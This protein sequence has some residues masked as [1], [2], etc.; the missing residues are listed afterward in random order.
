MFG[1]KQVDYLVPDR[2]NLGYG[3]SPQLA[4]QVVALKPDV[5]ITVDNGISCLQG[6][7][8]CKQAGIKV[9]VTDHHLQG[10]QL[11]N[12][13]AI[14]NHNRRDCP[15]PSKALAGCGVAF[16]LLVALRHYLREQNYFDNAGWPTQY[17]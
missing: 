4:E 1:F 9:I 13:D 15:F 6:V 14:V 12:A 5:L 8:I 16:Y 2:F 17:R 11:P 7:D 10:E 3:L